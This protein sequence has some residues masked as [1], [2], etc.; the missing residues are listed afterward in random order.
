MNR[1]AVTAL[2]ALAT[3]GPNHIAHAATRCVQPG[4]GSGCAPTIS[5]AVAAAAPGDTI[6][7]R[8]GTYHEDVTIT[9]PLSIVGDHRETTI[10]DANGF[11]NGFDVD[12]FDNPGLADV[13]IT[14]FTIENANTEGVLVSNASR[15]RL[16]D[17][18]VVGNDKA[19]SSG[20]CTVFVPPDNP[21]GEGLDCGEA[22]HLTG[23]D[24]SIVASNIVEHNSGG[25]LISDDS[26]P[27]HDN[28][29]T[30]NTVRENAFDCGITLASHNPVA[31]NGVYHNTVAAN[32]VVRNGLQ[33]E[34]AGVG[35][36]TPAPGTATFGNVVVGNTLVGNRLPGVAMHS[37]A[38]NQN[39][40]DNA[41]IGNYVADNGADTD[42]AQTPG[43]TGINVFGVSPIKGTTISQNVIEREDVAIAVKTASIV[44]A[45]FNSLANRRTGVANLGGG[46][47]DATENWWGCSRGP[48]RAGCSTVSGSV[49]YTPW[50]SRPLTRE[51]VRSER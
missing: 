22:I 38:P 2:A 27:T 10:V 5:A 46:T 26:G 42:D 43:R 28:A 9:K 30:G 11:D 23:V 29:I 45:H 20:A 18:R 19:L 37:H 35:M 50:L 41:I 49:E 13:S 8:R 44:D 32:E 12:G 24:H 14:G 17:N 51:V 40:D 34:G 21:Q 7:V 39:L 48:T 16:A 4:G 33:G 36:F 31:P 15:V 6:L 25:V 1:C 3:L 47:V